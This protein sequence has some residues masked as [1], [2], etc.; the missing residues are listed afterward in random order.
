MGI[1]PVE[2]EDK[3]KS[4]AIKWNARDAEHSAMLLRGLWGSAGLGHLRDRA[5][6]LR[7]AGT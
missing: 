7:C 2:N 6:L 5:R 4:P 1:G 3:E